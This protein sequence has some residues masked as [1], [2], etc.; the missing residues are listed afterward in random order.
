MIFM[1]YRE[2]F[3]SYRQFEQAAAT[4]LQVKPDKPAAAR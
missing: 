4:L 3:S 2:I 1:R